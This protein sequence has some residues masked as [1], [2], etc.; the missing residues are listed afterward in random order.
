MER[1]IQASCHIYHVKHLPFLCGEINCLEVHSTLLLLFPVD[2]TLCHKT[3]EGAP[4]TET[5]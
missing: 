5:L 4:V 1:S 2:I 3:P